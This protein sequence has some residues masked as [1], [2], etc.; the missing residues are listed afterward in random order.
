[1]SNLTL[2]YLQHLSPHVCR[3]LQKPL[4]HLLVVL[5]NLKGR[6]YECVLHPT[7]PDDE[8]TMVKP[9]ISDPR[10][11]LGDYWLLKKTLYR[12]CRS[13]KHWYA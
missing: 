4:C 9:P 12:L 3:K 11:K 6:L 8:I 7:L 10:A 1:M 13:R 5:G 2:A